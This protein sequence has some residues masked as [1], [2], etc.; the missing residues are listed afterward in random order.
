MR[1]FI[2]AQMLVIL[3]LFFLSV[4]WAAEPLVVDETHESQIFGETR[5]YLIFLPG[6]YATWGKRYPVIY[7]FHGWSERYNKAVRDDP[8]RHYDQ[9]EHYVG[10]TIARFVSNDDGI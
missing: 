8:H 1:C 6:D 9:G 10:N 5:H 3:L 4:A 7:W 2:I